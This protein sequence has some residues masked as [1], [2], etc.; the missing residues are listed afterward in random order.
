MH[1]DMEWRTKV[2]LGVLKGRKKR[3]EEKRETQPIVDGSNQLKV[4]I[5]CQYQHLVEIQGIKSIGLFT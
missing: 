5:A 1:T 2:R 4:A 3:R